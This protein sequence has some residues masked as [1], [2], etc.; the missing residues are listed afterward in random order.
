MHRHPIKNNSWFF[1]ICLIAAFCLLGCES[2]PEAPAKPKEVRQKIQQTPAKTAAKPAAKTDPA[3]TKPKAATVT[4]ADKD[5]GGTPKEKTGLMEA[6]S[7]DE[8]MA[9]AGGKE[10]IYQPTGRIDP[11][12]PIFKEEPQS[13][14][15]GPAEA[16]DQ[17]P[18]FPITP[19]TRVDLSQLKLTGIILAETGNKALV[20]EASGKGY[21]VKEGMY[22]GNKAGTVLKISKN[23]ILVDEKY[24]DI[25]T[26]KLKTKERELKLQKP[27]GEF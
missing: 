8:E 3:A 5:G 19:L 15:A 24:I 6:R 17:M 21:V 7:K 23:G 16:G 27:P 18:D 9:K 1:L 22:I 11:F 14:A 20:E 4:V 10:G 13:A 2:K 12:A 26:K 25:I